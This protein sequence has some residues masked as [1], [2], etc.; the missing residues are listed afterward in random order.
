MR[1]L[2]VRST[3][4]GIAGYAVASLVDAF[5]FRETL[6]LAPLRFFL[7]GTVAAAMAMLALVAM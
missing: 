2:L 5:F 7:A 1:P 6:H 4:W 3:V